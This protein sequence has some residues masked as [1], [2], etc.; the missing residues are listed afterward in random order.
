MCKAACYYH[1][2]ALGYVV[3]LSDSDG[4]SCHSREYS[5]F[6]RVAASDPNFIDNPWKRFQNCF[7][8]ENER[9]E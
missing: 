3:A 9:N 4:D 2:D 8:S 5:A 7:H 1:Y 6:G